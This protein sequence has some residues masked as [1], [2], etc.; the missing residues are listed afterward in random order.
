M[1]GR[2]LPLP[3]SCREGCGDLSTHDTIAP[4]GAVEEQE[5]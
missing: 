1:S 3:A 5:T 2:Y 4:E